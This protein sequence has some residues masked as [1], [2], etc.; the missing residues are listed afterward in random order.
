[1]FLLLIIFNF[2]LYKTNKY[3]K[4]FSLYLFSNLYIVLISIFLWEKY[5]VAHYIPT[6]MIY[7]RQGFTIN[8]IFTIFS[9]LL[10][11][12]FLDLKYVMLK[13]DVI[14]RVIRITNSHKILYFVFSLFTFIGLLLI[15]SSKWAMDFFDGLRLDQMIYTLTQPLKGTDPQQIIEFISGPLL[16]ATLHASLLLVAFY[17]FTVYGIKN[18]MSKSPSAGL[19]RFLFIVSPILGV[20]ILLFNANKGI[21]VIGREDVKTYFFETTSLYEDYYVEP[22]NAEIEFTEKKNLIYIMLESMESSFT[23][24]EYGGYGSENLIP[25]LTE[26]AQEEGIQFSHNEKLGGAFQVPGTNQTVTGTVAQTAGVPVRIDFNADSNA[27]LY[28]M[29]Q[30]EGYLPGAYS[31]GDVLEEEGYEQIYFIGSDAGFAGRDSYF[32]E[33]GDFEIR[34]LFWL[35]NEGLVPED[36]YEWWGVEDEKLYEFAKESLLE[37]ADRGKPFNFTML[38][39]NTHFPNGYLSD[40]TEVIFDEQYSNVILHAD[41]LVFEFISWIKEQ[42]F[43]QDTVIVVVGDHLSM[44]KEYFTNWDENY[45]RS[46]FN[47]YLN[48]DKESINNINREFTSLDLYPTTLSAMSV[49]VKNNRLGLGVDLFSGEPTIVEMIG[50]ENFSNELLKRSKY[51]QENILQGTDILAEVE[52]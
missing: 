43:Y 40:E 47:L 48:T 22:E 52:N 2:F 30:K 39:T 18:R 36:Y 17:H 37:L 8:A 25:R 51:Y 13:N 7:I 21:T 49:D 19:K 23:S 5:N 28:G 34:D 41:K 35:R 16:N 50:L 38:T 20:F 32:L 27:N 26:L 46:I 11:K 10:I 24:E 42:D 14:A 12:A 29:K 9:L 1:M 31:I 6:T 4:S 45:E 33:H 15:E 44:D 3:E